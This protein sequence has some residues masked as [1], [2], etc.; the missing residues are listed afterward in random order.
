MK[1]SL[2]GV[3]KALS[4]PILATCNALSLACGLTSPSYS[5]IWI[6]ET[7][8]GFLDGFVSRGTGL[9]L[10][11]PSFEF[12]AACSQLDTSIRILLRLSEWNLKRNS[13]YSL[14]T[15]QIWPRRRAML[16]PSAVRI[17]TTR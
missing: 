5:F 4:V 6:Y 12:D 7:G 13:G 16:Q 11:P 9:R 17:R 15:R 8:R 10:Q 2:A 1:R 14:R 3:K